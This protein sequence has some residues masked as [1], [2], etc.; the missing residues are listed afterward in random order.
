MSETKP[1]E[2][3]EINIPEPIRV[4][5]YTPINSELDMSYPDYLY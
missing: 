5:K 1:N 2:P 3:V 4:Q